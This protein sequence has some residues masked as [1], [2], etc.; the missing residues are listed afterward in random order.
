MALETV[1][2]PLKV[3]TYNLGCDYYDMTLAEMQEKCCIYYSNLYFKKSIPKEEECDVDT[4][5]PTLYDIYNYE[6]CYWYEWSSELKQH[7]LDACEERERLRAAKLI[8]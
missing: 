8:W 5:R 7:V 4:F 1:K 2:F 3:C 6:L